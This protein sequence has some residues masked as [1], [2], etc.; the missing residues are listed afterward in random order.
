MSQGVLPGLADPDVSRAWQRAVNPDVSGW[1]LQ[2]ARRVVERAR[3]SGVGPAELEGAGWFSFCARSGWSDATRIQYGKA[4]RACGLAVPAERTPEPHRPSVPPKAVYEAI[5]SNVDV[6]DVAWLTLAWAWPAQLEAFTK[7]R[8][9]Q[10][11]ARGD[12]VHLHPD[13][14]P[15][16]KLLD[17]RGRWRAWE[18]LRERLAGDTPRRDRAAIVAV[19]TDRFGEPPGTSMSARG[20]QAT[21][22]RRMSLV[23]AA[24]DADR[25]RAAA[26]PDPER[27]SQLEVEVERWG[28]ATF[29]TFRRAAIA[30]GAPVPNQGRGSVRA[31]RARV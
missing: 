3:A 1:A 30:N 4:L 13:G 6:R 8:A 25:R 5:V 19:H 21:F 23:S 15:A 12:Y 27:T 11:E 9:E 17:A 28:S 31:A 16:V 2:Q 18:L 22:R 10:L 7:L 20:L 14:A 26:I 29:E 24:L